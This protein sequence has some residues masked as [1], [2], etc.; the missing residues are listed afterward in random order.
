MPGQSQPDLMPVI[1]LRMDDVECVEQPGSLDPSNIVTSGNT[2]WLRTDIGGEGMFMPFLSMLTYEVHHTAER[3]DAAGPPILLPTG[4]SFI[5]NLPAPP[6]I[7]R[8]TSPPITTG[9]AATLPDGTYRIFTSLRLVAPSPPALFS[10]IGGF[11]QGPILQVI[12]AV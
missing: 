6:G 8:H 12:P 9:A 5:P 4:G 3:I 2:F 7:F 10:L 11:Y 1:K